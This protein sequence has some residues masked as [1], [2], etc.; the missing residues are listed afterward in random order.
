[1]AA[2]WELVHA[3]RAALVELFGEIEGPQ[4]EVASLCESWTVHDVLAHLASALDV[5]TA[6]SV[7]AFVAALGRPKV[8]IDNLTRAYAVRSSAELLAIYARHTQS[9]FAP[10]GLGW[11]AP[12]TDVMVHRM[13]VA[14]PLGI[15]PARP[16]ESWR[17]VLEFLTSGIPMLGSMR[18]GR[19]KVTW[20]ATDLD[21]TRGSGP[22]VAGSAEDVGLTLAGRGPR[23][24][25]LDGPGCDAV[26]RWLG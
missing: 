20:R 18:G 9:R 11:K 5:S 16:P 10:P 19:P 3:E 12:L 21:W 25:A 13:D 8:L 17:P 26:R 24:D 23:I 22:E 7:K 6:A 4:W 15:D 2:D 1:M 14:V